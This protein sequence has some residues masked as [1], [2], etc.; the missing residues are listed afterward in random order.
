MWVRAR[1]RVTLACVSAVVR[2][3]DL[4]VV[5]SGMAMVVSANSLPKGSILSVNAHI[6]QQ[7][8][9]RNGHAMA[10]NHIHPWQE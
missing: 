1:A 2:S 6:L 10:T 5:A 8:G 4:G 3:F 7:Y 9:R